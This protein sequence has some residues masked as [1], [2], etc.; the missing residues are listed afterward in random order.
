M[1]EKT[2]CTCK[3]TKN[4]LEFGKDKN[5]KDGLKKRCKLC[6]KKECHDYY[7]K[8]GGKEKILESM[9]PEKK[10]AKAEYVK[11]WRETSETYKQNKKEHDRKWRSSE[12]GQKWEK[13]YHKKYKQTKKYK[14]KAREYE[15][16]MASTPQGNLR[17]RIKDGIRKS[18]KNGKEGRSWEELVGYTIKDLTAHLESQFIDNMSWE[19]KNK[20]HMDHIIAQS[21]FN[22]ESPD[23]P[24]FKVCWSLENLRPLWGKDNCRKHAKIITEGNEKIFS[25]ALKAKLLKQRGYDTWESLQNSLQKN[26]CSI[27]ASE[28]YGF[29]KDVPGI[30]E[31]K[32]VIGSIKIENDQEFIHVWNLIN[33]VE[34]DFSQGILEKYK[35]GLNNIHTVDYECGTKVFKESIFTQS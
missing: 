10:K 35:Q 9:T 31:N 16:H 8:K 24:E 25:E 1:I 30:D 2:C 28:I 26:D 12:K 32:F 34:Y 3:E 29:C 17:L 20:W 13:E 23:D 33:G 27:I 21:F 19:N 18:L 6:R 22:Y 14:N 7:H 5:S 4:I 11:K 15:K